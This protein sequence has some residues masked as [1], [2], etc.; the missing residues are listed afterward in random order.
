VDEIFSGRIQ[1]TVRARI[2]K[3][4]NIYSGDPGSFARLCAGFKGFHLKRGGLQNIPR[5]PGEGDIDP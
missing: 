5:I 3:G 1:P 2:S 4:E